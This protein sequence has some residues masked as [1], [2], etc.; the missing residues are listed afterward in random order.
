MSDQWKSGRFVY[1]FFSLGLFSAIW[2]LGLKRWLPILPGF[3]N[4]AVTTLCFLAAAA[5]AHAGV[6]Q[7]YY[8]G[9]LA[10]LGFSAIGDA[11][12]MQK[13]DFFVP[14]LS[15][16]LI[17]HFCYLWAFMADSRFAR[18]W[19]PFLVYAAT[20]ITLV[21]WL[22][23][24]IPSALRLPVT[25]YTGAISVMAA[26]AASRGLVN[27]TQGSILA[28]V[29]AS[30]FVASDSVLAVGRFSHSF[31]HGGTVLLVCYFSAQAALALS[32]IRYG[33]HRSITQ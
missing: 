28:A 29:G 8:W 10:G 15:S 13:S 14:G 5:V 3:P 12:L 2:L 20:G 21:A 17:A 18:R 23:P 25:L 7:R 32:V 9:M 24:N 22:W 19:A 31:E 27:R 33:N 1:V 26:Q 30:L 11:F 16:F 6:P 4:T